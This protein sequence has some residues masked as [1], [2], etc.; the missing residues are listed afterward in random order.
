MEGARIRVDQAVV[1]P[2]PVLTH[3]AN[4]PFPCGNTALL[5]AEFALDPSSAQGGEIGGELCLD[6]AFR[7]HLC[8]CV[9]RKTEKRWEGERT[10]TRP[11]HLQEFPFRQLELRM[12]KLFTHG[13][14]SLRK[15]GLI[16]LFFI[17]K[18]VREGKVESVRGYRSRLGLRL[19]HPLYMLASAARD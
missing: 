12:C 18:D 9:L 13:T 15:N 16:F 4:T 7:G 11:A 5:G 19:V 14:N 17:P 8:P 2:I 1:F 3:P 10:K 6:E